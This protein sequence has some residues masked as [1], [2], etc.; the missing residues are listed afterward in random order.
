MNEP[1]LMKTRDAA[2]YMGMTESAL[3]QKLSNGNVPMWITK[4]IGGSRL[5]DRVAV[6][7]WLNG[8]EQ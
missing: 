4:K 1:R 3:R 2:K 8:L 7:R 6:D 5:Y